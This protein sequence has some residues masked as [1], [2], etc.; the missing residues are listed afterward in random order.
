MEIP[1]II[2]VVDLKPVDRPAVLTPPSVSMDRSVPRKLDR[3]PVSLV[4]E[5][6]PRALYPQG[7]SGFSW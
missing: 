3:D 5:P 2:D 1:V 4:I 7:V 6:L